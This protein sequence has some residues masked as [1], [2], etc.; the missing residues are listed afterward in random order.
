LSEVIASEVTDGIKLPRL[1]QTPAFAQT[2]GCAK[3][4]LQIAPPDLSFQD[5]SQ[6]FAL[7]S[8]TAAKKKKTTKGTL[9]AKITP[10][11]QIPNCGCPD[12][13]SNTDPTAAIAATHDPPKYAP[14]FGVITMVNSPTELL[15]ELLNNP[16]IKFSQLA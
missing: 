14:L 9:R 3:S 5:W 15:T 11:T 12:D 7:A 16:S 10:V 6:R 1:Q 4:S 8:L 2:P 13:N